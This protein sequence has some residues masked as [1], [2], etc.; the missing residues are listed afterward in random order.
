M[1]KRSIISG[2]GEVHVYDDATHGAIS[3]ADGNITFRPLTQHEMNAYKL[4][5]I[6]TMDTANA[7]TSK[8]FNDVLDGLNKL[9]SDTL[10]IRDLLKAGFAPDKAIA[11]LV[12]ALKPPESVDPLSAI[13]GFVTAKQK[14]TGMDGSRKRMSSVD[15]YLRGD[16]RV[17]RTGSSVD[18][19]LS[20]ER[21]VSRTGSSVDRYLSGERIVAR[22][23]LNSVDRYLSR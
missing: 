7:A 5:A 21:I 6:A 9:V 18:R 19:Y 10:P 3:D 12:T 17:A 23:G 8:R 13:E 4:K 14:A 1:A 2:R 16:H 20:G 15:R 22:P 11:L